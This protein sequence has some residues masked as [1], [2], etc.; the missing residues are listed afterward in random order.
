MAQFTCFANLKE[1]RE[2]NKKKFCDVRSSTFRTIHCRE[3]KTFFLSSELFTLSRLHGVKNGTTKS[4]LT[5]GYI[6]SAFWL[7]RTSIFSF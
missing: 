3:T 2:A 1:Q 6:K 7:S 4:R 5:S